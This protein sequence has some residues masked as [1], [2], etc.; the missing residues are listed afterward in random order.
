MEYPE[1]TKRYHHRNKWY[2]ALIKNLANPN[3]T[4]KKTARINQLTKD[5]DVLETQ[6]GQVIIQTI[7]MDCGCP[8]S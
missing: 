6:D 1:M 7:A 8:S 2:I 5:Q 3:E 4:M